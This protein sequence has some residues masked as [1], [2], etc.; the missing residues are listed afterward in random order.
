MSK[1]QQRRLSVQL[2]SLT[3]EESAALDSG[4]AVT[5]AVALDKA[6]KRIAKLLKS[7]QSTRPARGRDTHG[8]LNALL[9][10][11]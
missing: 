10:D 8:G 11:E 5:L 9:E 7:F 1:S 4:D 2:K 3:D 6:N